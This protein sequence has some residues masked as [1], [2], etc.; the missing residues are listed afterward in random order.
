MDVPR[1]AQAGSL[2]E[3][4]CCEGIEVGTP[5]EVYNRPGLSAIA[6]R[7]GTHARFKRSMLA[8]LSD[9][10]L[11][12]L[13]DLNTRD[14]DDFSV[15]LLDAWAT[16]ADVLTFYSERIANESYLRTATERVSLLQLARLI[17]YELRPGVAASSHLAFEL[18]DTPEVPSVP[19]V[20]NIE[21][22]TK[23][24]S[25]PGQ[26]ELPQTFE[27]VE[28]IEARP[29]WNTLRPRQT[30]PVKPDQ[31]DTE[32][33][34]K[35]VTTGLSPGDGLLLVGTEREATAGNENWDFRRLKT[36]TADPDAGRTRVTWDRGLG[37]KRFG[38][39]ILPARDPKAYALRQR[40][41]LFGQNAP[42]WRSMPDSVKKSY[43]ERDPRN[44]DKEW[45]GFDLT[46]D[47]TIDLDAVYPR[48]TQGSWVVLSRPNYE[49]VYQ[50]ETFEEASQTNFT[51]TAK[52]TRLELR[53]ENLVEKFAKGRRDTVVFAQSEAL[54]I[55][56]YPLVEPVEGDEVML[57]RR[58]DD[59]AGG[60][61]LIFSGQDAASGEPRSEPATLLEAVLED[62]LTKLRLTGDLAHS[63]Q[64]DTLAIH[65][66]VAHAT[67]GES[68]QEVLGS[69]DASTPFQR[70]ALRES[71]L[72]H[73]SAPTPSGTESTL[74]VRVD[75]IEWHEVP[76][77]YGRDPEERV[78]TTR[79]D[80]KNRTTV[81]FGDGRSGARLPTGRENI[82]A[83]YRKGIGVDGLVRAEQLSLLLTP[84]LGVRSVRNPIA[85]S[86]ADDPESQ[87]DAR[88]NAPLTVLTLD[89]VVSLRDYEDFARAYAGI[90]KALATWVWTG[91]TREV[92]VTVAAPAGREVG[93]DLLQ[94]LV[95]AI[96]AVGDR[97]L[98]LR[99]E[100]YR[101]A[102]FGMAAKMRIDPDFIPERVVAAVAAAL[103]EQFGFDARSF[104][105]GVALS[106]VLAAIQAVPG[107]VMVDVD[108]LYRIPK[109][110]RLGQPQPF[111]EADV[112]RQGEEDGDVLPAELL[113]LEP[114]SLSLEVIG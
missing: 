74:E 73:T 8:R 18:E 2:D 28:N 83:S 23:V 1:T 72:T 31:D 93:A 6:Y 96:R 35:G 61:T 67:H 88:L 25:L 42:D 32:V 13:R 77:L 7:I 64:R 33:Y 102:L 54:E 4:G 29:E 65:A 80:E 41:A 107:V 50:V 76:D 53:G 68:R 63:Y 26:D 62:N 16:V 15:A 12:V 22:G 92:L 56:E 87:D 44:T 112:T 55:A 91:E 3:C 48:I 106:E 101:P 27:T 40:A 85:A 58:V 81:L 24:Q 30:V 37:W 39:T 114:Q 103:Q 110:E 108:E 98:P 104:G 11:P 9:S 69:G 86:G 79:L 71:P 21:V 17:G 111:L 95:G 82:H 70:F 84:I 100:A 109:D 78:Y 46:S 57:D 94:N 10:R 36:V 43:L 90:A 66:N 45:P 38:R 49:E 51:L 97:H 52:T 113:T 20:V 99:V 75:D 59:L 89:R 60:R 34:L 14:D 47:D 5:A 19:R 105:Q